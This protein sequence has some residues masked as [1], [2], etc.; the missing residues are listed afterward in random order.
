MSSYHFLLRIAVFLIHENHCSM[1]SVKIFHAHLEIYHKEKIVC[2]LGKKLYLYMKRYYW[3]VKW[4]YV[5]VKMAYSFNKK[6]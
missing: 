6:P 5:L 2:I 1:F 3:F 4:L